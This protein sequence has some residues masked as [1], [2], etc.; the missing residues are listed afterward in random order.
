[1]EFGRRLNTKRPSNYGTIE[2]LL[3]QI[4]RDST[5]YEIFTNDILSDIETD[6]G[7]LSSLFVFYYNDVWARKNVAHPE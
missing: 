1:M 6:H 3:T 5:I 7:C 4:A 2:P